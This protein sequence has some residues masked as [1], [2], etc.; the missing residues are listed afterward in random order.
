[1]IDLDVTDSDELDTAEPVAADTA[2]PVAAD[3]RD[4]PLRVTVLKTMAKSPAHARAAALRSGDA[5]SL[6]L[7][8]GSG[9]HGLTFG[10]PEVV[11]FTGKQRR[12]KEWDEFQAAH[13]GKV[14]VNAKEYAH[15]KGMADAIKSHPIASRYL[16]AP[17]VEFEKRIDW[18]W[19]GRKW[20]STPDAMWFRGLAELKTTRCA[21]PAVFWRDALRMHY[22][23]QLSVYRRAI[24]ATTGVRPR[25]VYLFAVESS[26]PYV[27]T[28]FQLSD[29][30]LEHGDMLARRWHE[31]F[32]KCEAENDWPGYTRG[33]EELDVYD[34]EEE[35]AL[36]VERAM[37]NDDG[38]RA[39]VAW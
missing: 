22:H 37:A 6:A 11:V 26:Y 2:E 7:R 3:T 8:L 33:V 36:E 38:Q 23:V 21:D 5:A 17:G 15:A 9:T 39:A 14:I 32:L 29:R 24:E 20:R 13:A 1:M 19:D 10:T 4:M 18:E 35:A 28:A 25:E 34:A 16:F 30:S 31:Q 12:G 27:V